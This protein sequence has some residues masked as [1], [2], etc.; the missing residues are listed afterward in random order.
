VLNLT[1]A[2]NLLYSTVKLTTFDSERRESTATGFF[3][4][5]AKDGDNSIPCI[6]TNK[7][8]VNGAEWI[9]IRF[10]IADQ[11]KPSG[12]SFSCD[13]KIKRA[14]CLFHPDPKV[15]LCAFTIIDVLE[16]AVSDGRPVFRQIIPIS[17][18]PLESD[19]EFFDAL[20]DVIMVGCPNGIYDEVNNLPI[21]RRGITA[22]S[23]SKNYNGKNEFL[24]DMACYPGSSGSPIFVY[25]TNGFLDRQQ[26]AFAIDRQR[27]VF[28]GVLYA[29]PQISNYGRQVLVQP[30]SIAFD[31]MMHLGHAIRSTALKVLDDQARKLKAEFRERSTSI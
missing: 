10:H 19:W 17:F 8:V 22:S 25:N 2:E 18:I 21:F 23:L 30:A 5:L 12:R 20:E 13:L 24:V 6:I 15:D 28:V 27:L 1:I 26:N 29:G 4:N 31:T 9:S 14:S 7:H 16:R 3:M 11:N